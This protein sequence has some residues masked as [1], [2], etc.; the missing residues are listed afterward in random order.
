MIVMICGRDLSAAIYIF[1]IMMMRRQASAQ[2]HQDEKQHTQHGPVGRR[3]S[4]TT[5]SSAPT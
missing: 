5:S 1:F 4:H 2:R 3:A